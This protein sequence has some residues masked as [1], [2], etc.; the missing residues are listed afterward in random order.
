MAMLAYT[1]AE[2]VKLGSLPIIMCGELYS[3]RV[4]SFSVLTVHLRRIKYEC[5]VDNNSFLLD[6]FIRDDPS[7]ERPYPAE[8]LIK[9]GLDSAC[10]VEVSVSVHSRCLICYINQVSELAADIMNI[11][12]MTFLDS[13]AF[14]VW[15]WEW[16][17]DNLSEESEGSSTSITVIPETPPPGYRSD[18]NEDSA[19][20]DH[21]SNI[22]ICQL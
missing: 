12:T 13:R 8:A 4:P 17:D 3:Y 21:T 22:Q 7:L 5:I 14:V 1:N 19:D 20:E 9:E 16:K 15:R 18:D 2:G 6:G 10:F 11:G